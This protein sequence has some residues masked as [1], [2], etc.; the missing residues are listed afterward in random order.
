M[1]L[2]WTQVT[3]PWKRLIEQASSARQTQNAAPSPLS[4]DEPMP[5]SARASAIKVT[6]EQIQVASWYVLL[7][8][9]KLLQE[10]FPAVVQSLAG[11]AVSLSS[12]ETELA[13]ALR[14]ASL[15]ASLISNLRLNTSYSSGSVPQT[16]R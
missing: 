11:Q 1:L 4:T 7:D 10:Q 16:P 6:R 12:Q 15:S 5:A 8:F 13:N 14:A 9:A 2:F 3:E